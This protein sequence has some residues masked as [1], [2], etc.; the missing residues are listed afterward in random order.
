MQLYARK[1]SNVWADYWY[2]TIK[3]NV[4]PFDTKNRKPIFSSYK[5]YQNKRISIEDFEQWK[6]GGL[7]DHGMAI[8]PGRIYSE[9]GETL[10]LVVLDFDRKKGMEEFGN[11]WERDM[12]IKELAQRTIVEQHE[13]NL[14]RAHVYFL[15]PIP[16]PNK[17]A[18]SKIGIEVK[19]EGDME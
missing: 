11:C 2:K 19:S 18:D 7:F 12:T 13:D 6:K 15:S 3:V 5:D 9:D 14:D 4:I 17:G 16:F 1:T 10:Y 8:Y